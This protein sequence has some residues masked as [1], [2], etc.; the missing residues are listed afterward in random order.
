M[1]LNPRTLAAKV[2]FEEEKYS[3]SLKLANDLMNENI[4]LKENCWI[5]ALSLL[6]KE[7]SP[8]N[9]KVNDIF[10]K[11]IDVAC[12]T[13]ETIDEILELENN[14]LISFAKWER[15]TQLLYLSNLITNPSPKN[16]V[17]YFSRK[18]DYSKL[19]IGAIITLNNCSI[20]KQF[21]KENSKEYVLEYRKKFEKPVQ[22]FDAA[23]E[24]SYLYTVAATIFESQKAFIAEHSRGSGDYILQLHKITFP[25]LQTVHM[26]L[27][28]LLKPQELHPD[29]RIKWLSFY[30]NYLNY[31]L[32]VIVYPNG[33]PLK[34]F[35]SDDFRKKLNDV[36]IKILDH[37]S[38]VDYYNNNKK[39]I[40]ELTE[41]VKAAIENPSPAPSI[42][43]YAEKQ[44]T[45]EEKVKEITSAKEAAI[46]DAKERNENDATEYRDL[47][48][49][50]KEHYT[51]ILSNLNEE[52]EKLTQERSK[53]G[54][55]SF[56][57]KKELD[58][59]IASANTE[60]QNITSEYS[61]ALGDSS[62]YSDPA[63][64]VRTKLPEVIKKIESE[65]PL[66]K[67]PMDDFNAEKL[68][69]DTK[70]DYKS[71][72]KPNGSTEEVEHY[73]YYCVMTIAECTAALSQSQYT[74]LIHK[75]F[76]FEPSDQRVGAYMRRLMDRGFLTRKSVG[77]NLFLYSK[78][79]SAYS[80]SK[81]QSTD[82][83]ISNPI[84]TRVFEENKPT[85][86]D[87]IL[88]EVPS[89]AKISV[90]KMIREFA[91]VDLNK[92]KKMVDTPN[93]LIQNQVP[94]KDAMEIKNK[95]EALG[96]TVIL[97]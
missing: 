13:C 40:G 92:A 42:D 82:S 44:R 29:D 77:D 35:E 84:E 64:V 78:N 53:L 38:Y 87:I 1:S 94:E 20:Y 30:Q 26:I 95:L 6:M 7:T 88:S 91:N 63:D 52:I 36:Q 8:S 74:E 43:D 2:L 9:E 96:A 76:A 81:S 22:E 14:V 71:T 31:M 15:N 70:M 18:S 37:D 41:V 56:G 67:N 32:S 85:L 21:S 48:N 46:K 62:L 17:N 55:F 12:S 89:S 90:I 50:K 51:K 83:I 39:I 57:A 4:D 86:Y 80:F 34:I 79:S 16:Y 24:N 69:Y 45:W 25:K 68:W 3:D 47:I 49:Q 27:D 65:Y 61:E 54:M 5:G 97:K 28:H 19:K 75:C 73:I 59:K 11:G 10:L 58:Q 72:G 23:E 33:K 93:S 66:P 60:L